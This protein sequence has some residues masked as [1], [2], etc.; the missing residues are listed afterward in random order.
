MIEELECFED[1]MRA[2]IHCVKWLPGED[3]ELIYEE[4]G[5]NGVQN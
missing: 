1:V 2:W 5:G 4:N 3:R